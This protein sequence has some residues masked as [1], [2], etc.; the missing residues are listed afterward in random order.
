MDAVIVH[1]TFSNDALAFFYKTDLIGDIGEPEPPE[2]PDILAITQKAQLAAAPRVAVDLA[3]FKAPSLDDDVDEDPGELDP[4]L[5]IRK[6]APASESAP[7]ATT[8]GMTL[9]QKLGITKTTIREVG[10]ERQRRGF[11]ASGELVDFRILLP[12][13]ED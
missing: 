1:T 5:M 3:F 13:T 6:I 7:I 9:A 10:G 4:P 8:A 12:G 2:P 11:N